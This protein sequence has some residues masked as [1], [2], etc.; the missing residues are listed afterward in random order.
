MRAEAGN[1][2]RSWVSIDKIE[3]AEP[4]RGETSGGQIPP[5]RDGRLKVFREVTRIS[6]YDGSILTRR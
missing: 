2:I 6:I 1:E 3:P 5:E 4:N